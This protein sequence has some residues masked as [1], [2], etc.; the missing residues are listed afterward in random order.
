MSL[1]NKVLKDLERRHATPAEGSMAGL[2]VRALPAAPSALSGR[3]IVIVVLLAAGILGGLFGTTRLSWFT[4]RAAPKIHEPAKVMQASPPAPQAPVPSPVNMPDAVEASAKT[5]VQSGELRLDDELRVPETQ[6]SVVGTKPILV[7]HLPSKVKAAPPLLPVRPE[8]ETGLPK[9]ARDEGPVAIEKNVLEPNAR[10]RAKAALESGL[11]AL[12]R[13]AQDEAQQFFIASIAA[14]P[15]FDRGRQA[16]LSLLLGAQ[17]KAMAEAV[18]LDGAAHGQVKATFAMIGA[19]LQIERGA[20]KEALALLEQERAVGASNPDYLAM[21][22]NALAREQRHGES[23]NKYSEAI[24]LAPK[25]P[26]Y[27]VGLGYALRNDGQYAAA[28]AAFQRVSE[29][30]GIGTA[31]SNLAQQQL[32]SLDRVLANAPKK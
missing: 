26:A 4:P 14:D 7:A 13:K 28:R 11:E 16:L 29:M 8:P 24:A 32:Q 30:E 21:W 31:L 23:A 18:A 22:G 5:T 20:L 10:E 12:G 3:N 25:N 27:H 19:R 9:K 15:R 2:N 17:N 1:I 6:A